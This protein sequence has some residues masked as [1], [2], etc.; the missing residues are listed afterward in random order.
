MYII[1]DYSFSVNLYSFFIDV[2]YNCFINVYVYK[3]IV[4]V[5]IYIIFF[6]FV[7][8]KDYLVFYKKLKF[9]F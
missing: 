2:D 1:R 5:L 3:I 8:D 6:L 4:L 9:V 7:F